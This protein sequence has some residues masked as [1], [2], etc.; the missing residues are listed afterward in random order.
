MIKYIKNRYVIFALCLIVSGI[1]AFAVVPQS[2]RG[3]AEPVDVVKVTRQIEKNTEITEDMLEIQ[4][5][6]R[7]AVT[8]NTI[9]DKSQIIGKIA[10][11]PLLPEDN[12]VMQKF[13]DAGSASDQ[14][15]YG[16][17]GTQRLAVSVTV[18]SLA[19]SVS[20]K[21][22]PGDVVSVYGFLKEEKT[23][24]EYPDLQYVEVLGVSNS[25]AEELSA[26]MPDDETDAADSLIPAT[27]T[28][29][30]N[31]NQA[32]ELVILENMSSIHIVFAGRG[33]TSRN[34]IQ[35]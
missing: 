13:I 14:A 22:L 10:A 2:N 35:Y 12:L 9:T 1:I 34:L 32:R 25:N 31:Q 16:M 7:Q 3:M 33:E 5:I 19:A 21:I 28:L 24:A 18:S 8:D 4:Q 23:I 27:V 15:F 30:V 17:D 26:R 11:V 29:A 6:P 20:G